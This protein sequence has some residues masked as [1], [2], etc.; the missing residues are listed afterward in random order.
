MQLAVHLSECPP[1]F[2]YDEKLFVITN[3]TLIGLVK[4]DTH[5][6]VSYITPGFWIGCVEDSKDKYRREL[7]TTYCFL[8]F[9]NYNNACKKGLAIELPN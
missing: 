1:G 7:A 2:A 6:S 3:N 4:C 9:C 5:R 8:Y